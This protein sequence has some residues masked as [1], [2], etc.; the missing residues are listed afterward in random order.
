MSARYYNH[1]G[2]GGGGP[3]ASPP[4]Y[5]AGDP[6]E[7]QSSRQQAADP[8]GVRAS[9]LSVGD[10]AQG[11]ASYYSS[12]NGHNNGG[13]NYSGGGLA[14]AD[15]SGVRVSQLTAD[16][17]GVRV[18]QLSVDT[19][20]D[21]TAADNYGYADHSNNTRNQFSPTELSEL[22]AEA[23]KMKGLGNKHMSHQEYTRAYNAYSAALQ[24]SPVGPQSHVYL[25]N[26]AAALLSL[27][28][29]AAASVD[30][31]RA[32]ALAPSFGKAHARLGQAL[33]FL[34]DYQGAVAAY[35]EAVELEPDNS[36]TWTYLNKARQKLERQRA[37]EAESAAGGGASGG[38][39]QDHADHHSVDP[40][41]YAGYSVATDPHNAAA[42]VGANESGGAGGDGP[43]HIHTRSPT[44]AAR[45]RNLV[46]RNIETEPM[47]EH[48]G[49][50]KR[51]PV[52]S[53]GPISPLGSPVAQA[54]AQ[55]AAAQAE[56]GVG[57]DGN[58]TSNNDELNDT[59]DPDYDE[60]VALQQRA[61][62]YLSHKQYRA[63][64]EEFSAALFLVPDDAVFSPQLH[65]GRAHALNGLKRHESATNDARMAIKLNPENSAEA[66]SVLAKSLFYS[67]MYGEAIEAFEDCAER[68]P[69]GQLSKFD[70]AYLRKA[71]SAYHAEEEASLRTGGDT[72]FGGDTRSV[73]KSRMWTGAPVP[74]LPP[75]RFVSRGE[76]L[77]SPSSLT[78]MPR[79]WP[80]QAI[81]SPTTLQVGPE[82]EVIYFSE[83]MGVKLNRGPD[84]VVRVISAAAPS[85]QSTIAREGDM[86]VGDVIREAA[87]VDMR[88]PITNIMWG[89]TVALIKLAPRPIKLIVAPE[90]S[91]LPHSVREEMAKE[92]AT[93]GPPLGVSLTPTH[94]NGGDAG[95]HFSFSGTN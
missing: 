92:E 1:R 25:S 68:M 57:Q 88:R 63:A 64:V 17:T 70:Q 90:E 60:A 46:G 38:E 35:E 49:P 5:S 66:Y 69:G 65:I 94:A 85:A 33:Y 44:S 8:A 58:D 36:V 6:P 95:S 10:L 29:Y 30:A 42:V 45:L 26:R 4:S 74:K 76:V 53:G 28:R 52:G 14:Q 75:P 79:D 7:Y 93:G 22:Q 77:R 9:N 55:Q 37:K 87:G 73:A 56:G 54:Q 40:S 12:G 34:R 67:R 39:D 23:D 89:D 2:G 86:N 48:G 43:G 50:A 15:P 61:T 51:V 82:R 18:S 41:T 81:G 72:S 21:S 47:T 83:S 13:S 11:A 19:T 16:P 31:R 59:N 20:G 80:T 78:P 3:S 32:V 71:E 84:G 91:A 62:S 24:L 27:K